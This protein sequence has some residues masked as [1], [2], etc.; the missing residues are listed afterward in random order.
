MAETEEGLLWPHRRRMCAYMP[1][2]ELVPFT[3]P[4]ES[5]FQWKWK[6]NRSTKCE[7]VGQCYAKAPDLKLRDT[8]VCMRPQREPF[9]L[10]RW[11]C[12]PP[13]RA[14]TAAGNIRQ[15]PGT[16]HTT[17]GKVS[18]ETVAGT[19]PHPFRA[20][21]AAISGSC[22]SRETRDIFMSTCPRM[23]R[24]AVEYLGDPRC[25]PAPPREI[26]RLY[27]FGNS[28]TDTI[29]QA[30]SVCSSWNDVRARSLPD[31]MSGKR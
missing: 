29:H 8:Q 9:Q 10:N 21:Q 30:A 2:G 20:F 1:E 24:R 7:T 17:R 25:L 11:T 16:H 6:G 23:T 31:Q 3:A 19:A 28:Q 5:E 27:M 15:S 22:L 12:G 4:A 14:R 26:A 13:E 18:G